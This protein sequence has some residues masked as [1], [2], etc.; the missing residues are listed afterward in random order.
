MI[1]GFKKTIVAVGLLAVLL[2]L[3][4]CHQSSSSRKAGLVIKT[5]F[6]PIYAMTKEICGDLNDVQVIA[7]NTSIHSYEPSPTVVA[8]VYDGDVFIYH[9]KILE[10]WAADLAPQLEKKGL[11]VM[12]GTSHLT[13]DKVQ[14]L[15]HFTIKKGMNTDALYD[16]HTWTDPILASQEAEQIAALLSQKDPAHKAVYLQNA[17]RFKAKAQKLVKT[18]KEKFESLGGKTFVTQHTAFSY[19]AKRFDLKQLGIAG[20]SPE[21]EPS[22]RQLAQIDRF[23]KKYDVKT[24]FVEENASDKL[25]KTLAQSNGVAIDILSPLEVVPADQKTYLEHLKMNLETLY[26]VLE[27]ET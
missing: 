3:S 23:I 25:A 5:S 1:R 27:S 26:R 2:G 8:K 6:Y 14:G 9:S 10:A 24:I 16:P 13:L 18:Y 11:A 17:K 22:P 19:L 15:E 20:I 7:Q 21:Q 12:E 4:A